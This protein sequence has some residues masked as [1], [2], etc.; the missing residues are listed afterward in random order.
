M[1]TTYQAW[2]RKVKTLWPT[3]TFEGDKDIACA[4]CDGKG[5]GEWDG[6]VGEVKPRL[7]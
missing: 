2:R 5:V 6:A 4:F 1:L 3:A 7:A